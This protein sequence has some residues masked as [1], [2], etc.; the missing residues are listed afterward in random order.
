M[1]QMT[2]RGPD[3]PEPAGQAP[4]RM[5]TLMRAAIA[6]PTTAG[7]KLLRI[8]QVQGGKVVDERVI[9][10]RR[11]VTVGPSSDSTFVV[12]AALP[13]GFRLFELVKGTYYLA[14]APGMTARVGSASAG[15]ATLTGPRRLLLTDDSRGTVVVGETAFLFQLVPKP[16][17]ASTPRLPA[18]VRAG[19]GD[20]VDWALTAIAALSFLLHFG[21]IGSL[22]SDWSDVIVDDGIVAVGLVERL[23]RLPLP[24]LLEPLLPVELSADAAPT[25]PETRPA[26]P[27]D[28][29][30]STVPASASGES[31]KPKLSREAGAALLD[32]L[33]QREVA[34]LGALTSL[35]PSTSSVLRDGRVPTDNLE[36]FAESSSGVGSS[37]P[38]GLHLEGPGTGP[39]IPGRSGNDL[40]RLGS[41]TAAEGTRE[42]SGTQEKVAGPRGKVDG[43]GKVSVG[44]IDGAERVLAG[45]RGRIRGCYQAGLASSG[46]MTGRVAF[47]VTVDGSG[48]IQSVN[49]TSSGTLSGGVVQC[50]SGV[51][52]SLRFDAPE[53]GAAAVA[54]SFSFVKGEGAR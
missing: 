50:V 12:A 32:K 11:A 49:A 29:A 15:I 26:R 7:A 53:S 42:S 35:G 4:G 54:G 48:G 45:A 44:K 18:S 24:P 21:G 34:T 6:P 43:G 47:T 38:G 40:A 17:P 10:D 51:L 8:A 36:R 30:S 9:K 37:G 23:D 3:G 19:L 16:P 33:E 2:T 28:R 1:K 20:D 52:R 14:L 22:Y 46:D 13:P 41:R 5:T 25:Q 31:G 27:R 39:M